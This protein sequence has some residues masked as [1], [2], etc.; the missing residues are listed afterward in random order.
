MDFFGT[1]PASGGNKAARFKAI[2][3]ALRTA[4]RVWLA[5]VSPPTAVG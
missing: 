1:H 2:Q 3:D 4:K 5:A